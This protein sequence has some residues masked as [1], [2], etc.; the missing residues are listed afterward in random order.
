MSGIV[1]FIIKVNNLVG[2]ASAVFTF[3]TLCSGIG[4]VL[5][6]CKC[7]NKNWLGDGLFWLFIYFITYVIGFLY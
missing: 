5:N 6:L 7:K 1:A 2:T 4:S 3:V